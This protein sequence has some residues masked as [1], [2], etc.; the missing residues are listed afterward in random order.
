[1]RISLWFEEM[2]SSSKQVLEGGGG[3]KVFCQKETKAKVVAHCALSDMPLN[4]S[5]FASC[6]RMWK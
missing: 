6:G 5:E 3:V 2:G 4:H 1:M